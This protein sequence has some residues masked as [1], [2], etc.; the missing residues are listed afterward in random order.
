MTIDDISRLVMTSARCKAV[1]VLSSKGGMATGLS[2]S[3]AAMMLAAIPSKV[4]VV[5]VGD[6]L[7]D[8]GYLYFDLCRIVGESGVAM[9]P[10]GFK[11]DI[12]YGQIDPPNQI[13]RTETLSRLSAGDIRF[14]VTYPDAL[15]ESVASR[16]DL[17]EHTLT[18]TKDTRADM[19][20]VRAWLVDKGFREVDYVFEPG[21]F[22]IRGSIFDIFGYSAELPFRLDFFGD[23]I[24]SIRAFNIE[25]QLSEVKFDSVNIIANV[26][27]DNRGMSLLD[28]IDA[29]TVVA[30][31]DERQALARIREIGESKI[32]AYTLLTEDGDPDAMDVVIDASTSTAPHRAYTTRIST[33]SQNFS[34]GSSAKDTVCLFSRTTSVSSTDCVIFSPTAAI[35]SI[36]KPSTVQYTKASLT[37]SRSSVFSP[38]IRFSTDSINTPSRATVCCRLS[39]RA[40]I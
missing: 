28:F 3:S 16:D 1:R 11:R 30:F 36:S 38:T 25:T 7:D 18:L 29:G 34:P 19:N 9:L 14:V 5:V 27:H 39:S 6:G 23:E 35:R 13:L 10:S 22:A 21:Q 26:S 20:Q 12:K 32:S 24:D 2:G 37:M 17:S 15:A 40:T 33:L 4:P 31:R 8:A